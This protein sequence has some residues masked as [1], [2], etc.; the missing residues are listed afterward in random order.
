MIHLAVVLH[1]LAQAVNPSVLS[2]F[3]WAS[4]NI[5]MIAWPTICLFAWKAS[6]AFQK[7]IDKLDKT[8]GQIDTMATNHFPHME[9]ALEEIV[10]IMRERKLSL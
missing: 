10:T 3:Q 8:V 6:Q 9:R 2:P 4:Q 1:L 5:H 7:F